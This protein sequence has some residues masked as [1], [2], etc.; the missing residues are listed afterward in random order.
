[1]GTKRKLIH[2]SGADPGELNKFDTRI[3][4]KENVPLLRFFCWS[5][6]Q[7]EAPGHQRMLNAKVTV[8]TWAIAT[9]SSNRSIGKPASR[10]IERASSRPSGTRQFLVNEI[11]QI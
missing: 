11:Q 5:H 4:G 7:R 9:T 1:M 2:N 6:T 8:Q 3:C 10:G